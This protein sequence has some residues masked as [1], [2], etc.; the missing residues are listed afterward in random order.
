MQPKFERG[1]M[2]QNSRKKGNAGFSLLELL[3]A[4]TL[5]IG[6]LAMAATALTSGFRIREREESV[7]D[8][9]ADA[10]RGE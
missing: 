2:D 7:T 10:Q 5:T 3:I 8:A 1:L 9:V 4:M 6:M